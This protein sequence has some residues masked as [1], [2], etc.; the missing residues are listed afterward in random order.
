MA[1]LDLDDV[2]T[3]SFSA[4][5]SKVLLKDT[6]GAL[7]I[8]SLCDGFADPRL[9]RGP[10]SEGANPEFT[11]C[12]RYILDGSWDGVVELLDAETV[13][14]RSRHEFPGEMISDIHHDSLRGIFMIRQQPKA[15]AP[16][17]PPAPSYFS[18]WA[19]LSSDGPN[20]EVRPEVLHVG[21]SALSQDG[22]LLALLSTPEKC[23]RVVDSGTGS[24]L[25]R[26]EL[27]SKSGYGNLRW[28]PQGLLASVQR[29][30][31]RF[32]SPDLTLL[33]DLEVEQPADVDFSPD[34]RLVAIGSWEEGVLAT[35][36]EAIPGWQP[37]APQS[38]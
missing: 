33:G 21:S 37:G 4:D 28:S 3:I 13:T 9:L 22:S 17:Q 8:A 27:D 38:P 19:P 30:A 1:S 35:L 11:K 18:V 36:Q 25:A 20:H 31:V 26:R 10:T 34:G 12:G 2:A 16:D 5:S 24:I 6:G 14:R 23:L 32:Y 15:H 29:G 7:V